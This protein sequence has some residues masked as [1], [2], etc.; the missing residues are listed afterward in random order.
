MDKKRIAFGWSGTLVPEVGEFFC[1]EPQGLGALFFQPRLRVGTL[2]LL[3]ALQSEGWEIWI[4]TLSHLPQ[5]RIALYFR[6]NG[7]RLGGVITAQEHGSAHRA[8]RA[9]SRSQKHGPAFGLTLIADDKLG[10][11]Q[12]GLRHG[13]ETILVTNCHKD[14]TGPILSHCRSLARQQEP[15]ALALA[16]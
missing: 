14:W 1:E 8:G 7:I 10:T 13:F 12:A 11:R 16:A 9:P 5:S 4:Y 6:L 2:E 15:E 3:R